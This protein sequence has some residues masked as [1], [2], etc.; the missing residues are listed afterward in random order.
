MKTDQ[1]DSKIDR[2]IFLKNT[3][4]A[5]V[6]FTIIPRFVLGGKGYIPPSDKITLGFIGTGKQARGLVKNFGS[7]AQVVAAAD[8]DSQKL[9]LF[10]QITDKI[11]ADAT[12][13]ITYAGLDTYPDFSKIL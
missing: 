12:P 9:A 5:S 3:V 7:R 8:V 2:R 13:K 10:K 1:R 4:K 6:A 11:Y